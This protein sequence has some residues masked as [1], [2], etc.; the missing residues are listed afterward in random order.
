MKT[1][2]ILCSGLCVIAAFHSITVSAANSNRPN[3]VVLFAD[4]MGYGEVH[5]L[6]PK[7]GKVPTPHLDKLIKAGMTFTDA[8]TASSVC[9]PSRYALLTGRYC[10]RTRLQKGV[11][12]G[13]KEPLIAADR[14]TL[15]KMLKAKGYNTAM[16]GKWHLDFHWNGSPKKVG[17]KIPDGPLTRGFDTWLGFHHARSMNVL[18]KD[19]QVIEIIKPIE[20][21]PRTTRFAVDYINKKAAAA[22]RGTPFFLYMAFG[23]PHTPI[24]PTKEWI[25]KSGLGKY[26][27]FVMMTDGMAGKIIDAIDKNGLTDNTIVIFSADNGTSKAAGIPNLQKQGHYPSAHLRGSKADLWDGGHRVPFILRWPGGGVKAG[28]VCHQP[29]GL[30]DLTATIAELVGCAIPKNMA[31]DSISFLPALHGKPIQADRA[32]IVHHSI[33]GKFGIRKGK[34]KLLLAPGSGG[35]SAPN[36]MQA[37][38]KGLPEVQLYDM[39]T[40]VGETTNLQAKHPEVVREL[41]ELLKV[42][43]ANGR[44]TSG[45]PLKNDISEI[46]IFK[47]EG[48]RRKGRRGKRK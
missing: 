7:R 39:V 25:G 18:C 42:Y 27:D 17:T 26:G 2:P 16:S 48:K 9:T 4:D 31:E 14:L 36:D 23:S 20:M 6:N 34:W 33:S 47:K 43:V 1:L 28:S 21:L 8:H 22:K 41:T 37:K 5:G 12:T 38:K 30:I 24:V 35:W 10:W 15:G 32:A 46:D 45:V 13:G 19:D 11:L 40:D 3:I 44:S 29:I